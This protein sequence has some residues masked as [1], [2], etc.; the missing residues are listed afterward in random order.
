MQHLSPQSSVKYPREGVLRL[1]SSPGRAPWIWHSV[2]VA[3]LTLFLTGCADNEASYVGARAMDQ[4]QQSGLGNPQVD[5]PI[6]T[7][8]PSASIGQTAQPRYEWNGNPKAVT[9]GK[10]GSLTA[11]RPALKPQPSARSAAAATGAEPADAETV[12]VQA[13]DTLHGI[14]ERYGVTVASLNQANRLTGAPLQVGQK[15]VLPPTAR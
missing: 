7:P 15:L 10:A 3:G 11:K 13:G 2:I 9:E 4:S 14:A 5:R 1:L 8:P 6:I 12:E